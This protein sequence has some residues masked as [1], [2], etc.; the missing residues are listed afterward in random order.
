MQLPEVNA[1]AAA[2]AAEGLDAV[3]AAAEGSDPRAAHA[4]AEDS[5]SRAGHAAVEGTSPRAEHAAPPAGPGR[6]SASSPHDESGLRQFAKLKRRCLQIWG[7][8]GVIALL[9]VAIYLL[10]ILAV[11]VGILI[12]TVIIVFCLRGVVNNLEK[13]GIGRGIGTAVAYV[14]MAGVIAVVVYLM[15]SPA[16]GVGDQFHDLVMSVPGYINRISSWVS[17]LYA[18]YADVFQND[19]VHQ[20]LETALATLSNAAGDV[21]RQSAGGIMAFGSGVANTF[22][23]IGFALVVAYWML[24]ELPALGREMKRLFGPEHEETLDFLHV[25]FTRVM[26]GYIKGTLLQCAVIGVGCAVVFGVLGIRNYVALGVIAGLLNIIPIIGPW[27]GGAL[28]AIVGIFVSPFV[29]LV[30]LVATIA[31]QQIVYTFVSPRIMASSVDVHPALTIIALMAGSALG[32]A[33]GE[34]PGSLI[35]M[36]ASIPAVAVAKAVFVYY[37]EKRTGRHLVAED[38][39][40]FQ[41]TIGED[42]NPFNDATSPHPD[43]TAPFP[44]LEGIGE[45][46]AKAGGKEPP[47]AKRRKQ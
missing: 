44:V 6:S 22:V 23:A 29:A 28:A 37:F 27:F 5:S 42:V 36:L 13:R 39:V 38:G 41:G 4:A 2:E 3:H 33:M 18:Q 7:A 30:A 34:L 47:T 25:T 8:I 15:C 43:A 40:F 11:P 46:I 20:W 26:G 21:A 1:A 12:W 31:I 24:L 9:G 19:T 14:V 32:G 35:G 17:G 10:D 16:L 45:K